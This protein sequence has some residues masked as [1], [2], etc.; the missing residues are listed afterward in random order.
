[1]NGSGRTSR[2]HPEIRPGVIEDHVIT[3]D[4]DVV[5]WDFFFPLLNFRLG[6]WT[7]SAGATSGTMA[8]SN[9]GVGPGSM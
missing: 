7:S 3:G 8:S 4:T 9:T 1:M 6:A 5:L 2:W